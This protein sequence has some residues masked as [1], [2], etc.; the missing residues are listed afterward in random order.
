[1][2]RALSDEFQTLKGLR[3][4]GAFLSGGNDLDHIPW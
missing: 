3:R 2:I 1:M 4:V